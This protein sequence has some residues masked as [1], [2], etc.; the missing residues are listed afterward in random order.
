MDRIRLVNMTF[1]GYH[2]VSAAEKETGRRYE[3]DC[4]LT[5]DLAEP[6]KT[7]RLKDTIDYAAVYDL[8]ADIVQN[9]SF[10][11]LEGLAARLATDILEHF[12]V[13]EVT[14]DVRKI[15]PPINGQMDYIEVEVTRRQTDPAKMLSSENQNG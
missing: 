14:V 12:G 1:Y 15:M 2:G 6:G 11:L 3:V 4:E 5:V 10:S 7:D 13:I 9:R 8:I